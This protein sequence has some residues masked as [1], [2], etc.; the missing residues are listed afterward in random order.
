MI[1]I[2]VEDGPTGH[3]W[4][5]LGSVLETARNLVAQDGRIVL[6]TQIDSAL[7]EGLQ[8][9]SRCHEPLDAIKPLRDSQPGDLLAATQMAL[10]GDWALICLLSKV[11]S[12]EV[13]D[14]FVIP[15]EDEAEVQRLLQTDE[16]VSVI[17]SAQYAYGQLKQG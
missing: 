10:T 3:Q 17:A 4:N 1:I 8:I 16:T 6:L 14:L 5:Q 9:L 13:E 12:D 7:G 15:L 11:S 2:A